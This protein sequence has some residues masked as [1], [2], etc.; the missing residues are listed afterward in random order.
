MLEEDVRALARQLDVGARLQQ[1]QLIHDVEQD[2]RHLV[3]AAGAVAQQRA[4]VDVGEVGVRATLGGGHAHLGRRRVVVELDEEAL[5]QFARRLRRQ[6]AAGQPLLVE[7]EQV[8]LEMAGIEC[9]PAV[10]LG[11]HRQV[12][13]PVVLQR[14][15]EVARRVRR[16]VVA[17]VGDPLELGPR[18]G[19]RGRGGAPKGHASRHSPHAMQRFSATMNSCPAEMLAGLWHQAHDSG[20]PFRRTVARMPG[21]S[22]SEQRWML[23]TSPWPAGPC[24]LHAALELGIVRPQ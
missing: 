3:G 2:V 13:G 18:L 12:T 4:D 22:W 7:R 20:H 16:H 19:V 8:L 15:V 10:E 1:V 21:L 23:K 11:D 17:G 5:E 9:I 6:R 14:L 24:A